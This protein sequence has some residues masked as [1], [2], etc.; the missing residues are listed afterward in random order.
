[1]G[2]IIGDRLRG[3]VN[4]FLLDQ[5]NHLG[6]PVAIQPRLLSAEDKLSRWSRLWGTLEGVN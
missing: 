4:S 5:R 1:V 2:C 3:A 6:D